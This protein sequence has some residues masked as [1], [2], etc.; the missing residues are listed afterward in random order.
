MGASQSALGQTIQDAIQN[1]DLLEASLVFESIASGDQPKQTPETG[2]G[3]SVANGSVSK[4]QLLKLQI[5]LPTEWTSLLQNKLTHVIVAADKSGSMSGNPWRQVQQA[6]LYMIGDVAS[7]N[8]SV[9]LDVVIYNDEASLLQYA[10]SYQEAVNRVKADGMTSF[11]AAFSCIK[12]CLKTE[13]QGTPVSKTVVVFMTDGADTCNRGDDINRSVKSWKEALARLGHEAIV[14]VVGFSAQ[15]DYNFL[16]RLRNTGT[17]A[18]LFRYTEPSDGTEAL[19]AKLQELFDFVAL[20]AGREVEMLMKLEGEDRFYT[21][22]GSK[23]TVTIKGEVVVEEQEEGN[24]E[25]AAAASSAE[26]QKRLLVQADTWVI[27][28]DPVTLPQVSITLR[29]QVAGQDL[30]LPCLVKEMSRELVKEPADK[31]LWAVRVLER[32]ADSLSVRLSKAITSDGDGGVFDQLEKRLTRLQERVTNVQVYGHKGINKELRRALLEHLKELQGKIDRMHSLVADFRRAQGSSVSLLAK[33]ND[34]R[35]STQFTKS[36]RQRIMDKRVSKNVSA[37]QEAAAQLSMLRVDQSETANLSQNALDFF[38]CVLSQYNVKELLEDPDDNSDVLGFGLAIRRSEHALDEPTL[39]YI[40]GVSGSLVS[41]TSI[42]EAL[43]HKIQL[44]G[45][46]SAHGGFTFD[47]DAELGVATVGQAREPINSWLPLY[48]TK[49]HWDRVKLLMAPS[50]GYLCTLDPL[51]FDPKQQ[52]VLLMVLGNMISRLDQDTTGQHQLRLL[53]AFHRTCAA[54][55]ADFNMAEAVEERVQNFCSS[56]QG[57]TKD[58]LVNLYTLIGSVVCLPRETL[59]DIF[60]ENGEKLG[61]FW[62]SFVAEAYRRAAGQMFKDKSDNVV[63]GLVDLLLHGEGQGVIQ[64]GASQ[65]EAPLSD[66]T[67]ALLA[68]CRQVASCS[69]TQPIKVDAPVFDPA[70]GVTAPEVK[71]KTSRKVDRAMEIWAKDKLGCPLSKKDDVTAAKKVVTRWLDFGPQSVGAQM[72]GEKEAKKDDY[73]PELVTQSMLNTVAQLLEKL[74]GRL[75]PQLA[76]LPSCIA[77]VNHWVSSQYCFSEVDRNSG[78][79]PET[80][81][82]GVKEA[83]KMMYS[84]LAEDEGAGPEEMSLGTNV[85]EGEEDVES[86]DDYEDDD[87]DTD[88]KAQKR[89]TR[90]SSKKRARFHLPSLLGLVAPGNDPALLSRALVCQ[91]LCYC[92]NSKARQAA[93]TGL[94]LDLGQLDA[95]ASPAVL[96]LQQLHC[97]LLQR[98]EHVLQA[99]IERSIKQRANYCMVEASTVWAFIGYLMNTHKERDDGFIDLIKMLTSPDRQQPIPLVAEKVRILVTGQYEGKAVLSYGNVWL[100]ERKY[101]QALAKVVGEEAWGEI[102][103]EVRS[104]VSVHVYR[105]SDIPNRHGHCNSNPYIPNELRKRLGMPLRTLQNTRKGKK[106]R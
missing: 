53:F 45:H 51:G 10:G 19:K 16:G 100:P 8:P 18:G 70:A 54:M 85:D 72:E 77:F 62:V 86:D 49:S 61:S 90:M 22:D 42:L 83:I 25:G 26:G 6:L 21:P 29:M 59:K 24:T 69:S 81:I 41:R 66:P 55:V 47:P 87:D 71:V 3:A 4:E 48:V 92:S 50:L 20:S 89:K 78:L 44:S 73:N 97:S 67:D 102:E 103:V 31:V 91:V 65:T 96:T 46:L 101:S 56:I 60:G 37:V 39:L 63:D 13:I 93:K 74:Q 105:E 68:R 80:W 94:M 7:V 30:E 58:V 15:H 33:A 9:A 36:R 84:T 38:H 5:P 23:Q 64:G 98:R 106:R 11:A 99:M 88:G 104:N 27:M 75:T 79:A 14:H 40:H 95:A 35:F 57:R 1:S 82:S 52:D 43:E 12:E 2:D 17:T 76:A 32:N 34:L 28:A